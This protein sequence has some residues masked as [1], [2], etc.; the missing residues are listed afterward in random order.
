MQLELD[1]SWAKALNHEINK[2]YYQ[3]LMRFLKTEYIQNPDSIFP[4]QTDIFRAFNL[5]SIDNTKLVIIGQDPY[6]TR[7][8]ANGLSF[9]VNDSVSPLPRSLTNIFKELNES[10]SIEIP[11]N[12]NLERWAKQG[13]LLLNNV[14]TVR[15]SKPGSHENQGWEIFTDAVIYELCRRKSNLVFLLWGSKAKEKAKIAKRY[16]HLVLEAPHPS[17]LSAYKGFFGCNHFLLAN[18]YLE[19]YGISPIHW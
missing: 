14:L 5:C 1:Q 3:N 2:E 7:G 8:Y 19:N 18:Q 15:E 10:L 16:K 12:G 11:E 6:P 13:V 9:S 4:S 17:P